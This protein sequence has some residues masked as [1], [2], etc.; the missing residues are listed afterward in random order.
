MGKGPPPYLPHS[1]PSP[2]PLK[3]S[4][5]RPPIPIHHPHENA[6]PVRATLPQLPYDFFVKPF[7]VPSQMSPLLFHNRSPAVAQSRNEVRHRQ[8]R[9]GPRS[10]PRTSS[11]IRG[12]TVLPRRSPAPCPSRRFSN[13]AAGPKCLAL[14]RSHSNSPHFSSAYRTASKE[15][16]M[17]SVASSSSARLLIRSSTLPLPQ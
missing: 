9:K 7:R 13:G 12:F 8:A 6:L 1:C 4:L 3:R 14:C 10:T 15:R 5:Q 2:P 11:G 16:R 17:N